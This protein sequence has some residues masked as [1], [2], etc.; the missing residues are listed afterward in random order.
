MTQLSVTVGG[1]WATPY[2]VHVVPEKYAIVENRS[3]PNA[4]EPGLPQ[5]RAEGICVVRITKEQSSRFEAR[6]ERYK[7]NAKPLESF[8]FEDPD[9]RP[10]G[11]PCENEVTDSKIVSLFWTGSEG[12]IATFYFGCDHEEFKGFYNAVLAVTDPL[13]I[14]G[15]IKER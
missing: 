15:L 1:T 5:D 9:L 10:D 13:P 11:K 4:K 14:Q 2:S 8:S 12:R 7:R 3:C 6:M